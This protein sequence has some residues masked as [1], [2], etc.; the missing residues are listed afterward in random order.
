MSMEFSVA[1][2]CC[3]SIVAARGL[4]QHDE[5]FGA[6]AHGLCANPKEKADSSGK[7]RLRNDNW[8]VLLRSVLTATMQRKRKARESGA[9]HSQVCARERK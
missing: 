1:A 3:N 4:L 5:N 2:R 8:R 6:P 7:N 9:G